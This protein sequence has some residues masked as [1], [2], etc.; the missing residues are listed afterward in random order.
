MK[1]L[2]FFILF[3]GVLFA[4]TNSTVDNSLYDSAT[5]SAVIPPPDT[6]LVIQ[7]V[8]TNGNDVT[9]SYVILA[10][11]CG[12]KPRIDTNAGVLNFYSSFSGASND[13]FLGS[14]NYPLIPAGSQYFGSATYN[15][16]HSGRIVGIVD[17]TDTTG[18]G[19][20]ESNNRQVSS[21]YSVP[22]TSC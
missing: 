19:S 22:V 21:Y 7:N 9:V 4:F 18:E 3:S 14:I 2:L 17:A 15:V 10:E 11:E 5:N 1:N 8:S 6:R 12:P 20:C 16:C 13:F